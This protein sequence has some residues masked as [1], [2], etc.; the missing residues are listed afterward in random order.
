MEEQKKPFILNIGNSIGQGGE[1]ERCNK[2]EGIHPPRQMISPCFNVARLHG[3]G[4]EKNLWI[5]GCSD[6]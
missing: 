2:L 3:I 6:H 1:K 4:V 5:T